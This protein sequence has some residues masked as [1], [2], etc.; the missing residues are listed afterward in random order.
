MSVGTRKNEPGLDEMAH[1]VHFCGF[2]DTEPVRTTLSF[3]LL[4]LPSLPLACTD[5]TQAGGGTDDAS[6]GTDSGASSTSPDATTA[7]SSPET[8]TG[9]SSGPDSTG[10]NPSGSDTSDSEGDTEAG[11][12]T[13]QSPYP[14]DAIIAST[15]APGY[16]AQNASEAFINALT[17]AEAGDTVVVDFVPGTEGVWNIEEMYPSWFDGDSGEHQVADDVTVFFEPGVTLRAMSETYDD[18]SGLGML[19]RLENV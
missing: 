17:S 9:S 5:S 3:C 11:P 1:G 6:S 4:L 2:K 16:D 10:S 8:T 14:P 13:C 12:T 19:F 7:G 18:P 15:V